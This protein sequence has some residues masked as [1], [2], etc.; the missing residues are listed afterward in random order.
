MHERFDRKWPTYTG[1]RSDLRPDLTKAAMAAHRNLLRRGDV[2]RSQHPRASLFM[3]AFRVW[4]DEYHA[5]SHGG[6]GMNNRT[7]LEAFTE[8]A[9][10]RQLPAPEPEQLA[11]MLLERKTRVV[12]ECSV[13]LWKRR[14]VCYDGQSYEQMNRLNRTQVIVAYDPN[15][16]EAVAI[17]DEEGNFLTWAR[18]EQFLPQSA[19]AGPAI[20]ASMEARRHLEKKDRKTLRAI[21]LAARSGG[22]KSEVE[23]LAERACLPIAVGDRMTHGRPYTRPDVNAVAPPTAADIASNFLEALK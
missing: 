8:E 6:Q 4:L 23:H 19:E 15:D 11:V 2:D 14:Y 1:G 5:T 13:E 21:T 12:Q 22:A 18:A 16:A 20:A 17:L 10:P 9:N 7:P 3:G